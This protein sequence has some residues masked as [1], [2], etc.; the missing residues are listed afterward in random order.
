V[1]L[2]NR[3]NADKSCNLGCA[4]VGLGDGAAMS[5]GTAVVR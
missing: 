4:E 3:E 1:P 2:A 5:A